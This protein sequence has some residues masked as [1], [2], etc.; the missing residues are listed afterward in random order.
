VSKQKLKIALD[1]LNAISNPVKHMREN[2]P[3]GH[4]LNGYMASQLSNDPAYLKDL[5]AKALA[6]IYGD[7][8][9]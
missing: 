6:Q 8:N 2:L 5:A 4:M 1:A 9:G 3:D 7:G